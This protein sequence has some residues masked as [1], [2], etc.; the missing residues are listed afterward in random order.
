MKNL[1]K[2]MMLVAVAAMAFTACQ[3]DNGE[4]NEVKRTVDFTATIGEDTRSGFNG[5]T[6]DADGKTYYQSNWDGE[7]M[8]LF[9]AESTSSYPK[10][11]AD[12][13]FSVTLNENDHYADI[14]SPAGV[15]EYNYISGVGYGYYPI[16]PA[17]QTPRTN[18][19]DPAAHILSAIDVPVDGSENVS[20]TFKHAVAYGKMT[21]NTPTEFEITKVVLNLKGINQYEEDDDLTY[22][23][24]ATNV[25]NNEF[26]FA[27]EPLKVSEFTITA[28]DSDGKL[29]AKTVTV[30][31]GKLKFQTGHVSTFSVSNLTEQEAPKPIE[32]TSVVYNYNKTDKQLTFT[33]EDM[34]DLKLNFY[35]DKTEGGDYLNV[36]HYD[37]PDSL[38]VGS[39]T[40]AY[41]QPVG[42]S[43]IIISYVSADISIVDGK[44]M[45]VFHVEAG[46]YVFDGMYHGLVDGLSIPDTRTKLATPVLSY[47][48]SDN[49]TA[50]VSWEPIVNAAG[51]RVYYTGGDGF[52]TTTTETS[53][54]LEFTK[55][56]EYYV[57]VGALAADGDPN[58]KDSAEAYVYIL[59]QDPRPYLTVPSNVS[60]TVDG[61]SATISW[62]PVDGAD[63]YQVHYY[64]NG[65]VYVDVDGTSTTL[66]LGYGIKDLYVYVF[67][68][69]YDNNPHYRSSNS[70]SANVVINTENDPNFIAQYMWDE[71]FVWDDAGYFILY[72]S[73][74]GSSS[75]WRIYLNTADRPN[76]NSIK[77]GTYTGTTNTSPSVGEFTVRIGASGVAPFYSLYASAVSSSDTLEVKI[78][79]EMYQIV[80]THGS[81]SYG[82]KGLPEEFV[83]P[84]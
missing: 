7:E 3:K 20:F 44:Y 38:Y 10:V 82:Y 64:L 55:Y 22:T 43:K 71:T 29:M 80:F 25:E 21:V 18:S 78:V 32:F 50:K 59:I 56:G 49:M 17:T 30:E 33:S 14:Y 79:D 68:M 73:T 61:T 27:T 19:V 72:D 45:F 6:T 23:I 35:P 70:W 28:H 69:A 1:F 77:T 81:E 16:V 9:I 37:S 63:Y 36:G 42:G 84:N 67:S 24:N 83:L 51:Y 39:T 60:A 52:E 26:W 65:N 48:M 4:L 40:Y 12:G 74:W 13:K 66:D 46:D 2:S 58:Y 41:F 15:W 54:T 5:T 47:E 53:I 75:Y 11:D 76:N 62:L 31:E 8:L 34:G 57:N